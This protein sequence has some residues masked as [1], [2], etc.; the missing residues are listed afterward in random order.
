MS[1][2]Q[3]S[4][5]LRAHAWVPDL[6]S[7]PV[8]VFILLLIN[9]PAFHYR[10]F[11][12]SRV[13]LLWDMRPKP[14]WFSKR[15]HFARHVPRHDTDPPAVWPA[16][17]VHRMRRSGAPPPDETQMVF[18][19]TEALGLR[20]HGKHH[21]LFATHL[22]CS[23]NILC[24]DHPVVDAPLKVRISFFPWLH[25]FRQY[26]EGLKNCPQVCR[27]NISPWKSFYGDFIFTR[28]VGWFSVVYFPHIWNSRRMHVL[29][30]PCSILI[31]CWEGIWEPFWWPDCGQGLPSGW[32]HWVPRAS[33]AP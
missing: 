5:S 12:L 1:K 9:E 15:M 22:L 21:L 14:L 3:L 23:M 26:W 20:C 33:V 16:I 4:F 28:N 32:E 7:C 13:S 6:T 18:S 19:L 29:M 27:L 30:A 17:Q 24:L 2:V 10:V 11:L 25:P 8:K 31:H